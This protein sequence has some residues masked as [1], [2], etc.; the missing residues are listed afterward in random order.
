LLCLFDGCYFGAF[1]T[2]QSETGYHVA[3]AYHV[4][5]HAHTKYRFKF[6][7]A[8]SIYL[9]KMLRPERMTS[10]SIICVKKDVE[11]ILETLNTFG[12][13][14]IEPSAQENASIADYDRSIQLVQERILDVNGLIK[15]LV[16]EKGSLLGIFKVS[17]PKKLAVTADNWQQLLENTNQDILTLKKQI[18]N[19]NASLTGLKEKAAGLDH[20]GKMLSNMESMGTDLEAVENLKLIYVSFA[21]I[22]TKNCEAFETAIAN[23]PLYLNRCHI[24]EEECF[25]AVA[26]PAKHKEEV[27]RIL[28][29]Y[30]ADIFHLPEDLP[31]NVGEAHKEVDRR[32]KE[33]LEKEKE[34]NESLQKLG[35]ENKDQLASWKE[36]SENILALLEAEKKILQSGRLA[37]IKGYVPQNKFVE[38]NQSVTGKMEGKVL[39]LQNDADEHKAEELPTKIMHSRWIKPFEEITKLYGLPK[40]M[41]VDPTPFIAISFP[42]LFGLMF[43]DLGHG[44]VLLLG[45]LIVGTLIKGNQGIK[46]ICWI[47]AACGA[48]ACVAGVL[49]G[50]FFGIGFEKL[51]PA[52]GPLWY[53][54]FESQNVFNFLIFSLV[55]G[56]V[57]I[58][59]G[60]LIELA[61][62]VATRNYADAFLTAV[63]QI[64]FYLGGVYLI[65]TCQLEFG[66]WLAG[67]I[68][69]PVIPFAVMVAGKPLYLKFAKPKNYHVDAEH[70]E[71]DTITG[72][73]FEGGD[74][75]TRLLSNTISYSRILALLMAHWALLLVVYQVSG[76]VTSLGVLGMVLAGIII[77]V[78]NIGVIALEG[79]IVFIHTLRLHFYE[80]FSKFYGGTGT[81]FKPFKQT[82]NRTTLTLKKKEN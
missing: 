68:L 53:S 23:L 19:L 38:L 43:G 77:V 18:E 11:S 28:R 41:E 63:P 45:G 30:H 17:E 27:E 55:V 31:Q 51:N 22:P 80:W 15:Q 75:F 33:S 29:T 7:L 14:H 54:P 67:P 8:N 2:D 37:T 6:L 12:E 73:L 65:A 50:E 35:E 49:F 74:F 21:S 26:A 59:S 42:I 78:G 32:L 46:N 76:Q 5:N 70:A 3:V 16:V 60:I 47:M 1:D 71:S 72:R 40:Y 44:L 62:Y 79:L 66:K 10:T 13:F 58:I 48:A 69:A 4:A 57:Q 81:E 61:N 25:V 52:W 36:T 34:I 24:C 20:I 56:I 64:A 39:V 82:F 9:L